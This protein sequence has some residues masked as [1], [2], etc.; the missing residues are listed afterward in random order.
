VPTRTSSTTV[1]FGRPFWL[2]GVDRTLPAG[3]Y[4]VTT[5]EE[6]VEGL[7]FPVYRRVATMIL[8]PAAQASSVEMVTIDPADLK[9]A[10]DR[11]AAALRQVAT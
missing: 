7:S 1:T 11:D 8:V 10:Q 5:D 3:D 9:A 6:L 4:P 2:K